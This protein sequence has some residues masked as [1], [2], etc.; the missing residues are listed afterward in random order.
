MLLAI[1]FNLSMGETSIIGINI[2]L[3]LLAMFVAWGRFKKAAIAPK[4]H[5]YKHS[6]DRN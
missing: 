3:F 2:L 5:L 1:L 4:Y 6:L